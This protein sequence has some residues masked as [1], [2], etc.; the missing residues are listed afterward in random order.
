MEDMRNGRTAE[1]AELCVGAVEQGGDPELALAWVAATVEDCKRLRRPL[2]ATT[3]GRTSG[4]AAGEA[5]SKVAVATVYRPV[6]IKK[7]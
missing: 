3:D 6:K 2:E 7:S 1:A 4:A 5:V